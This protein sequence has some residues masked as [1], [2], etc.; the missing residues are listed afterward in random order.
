[1]IAV[2]GVT[3]KLSIALLGLLILGPL[4]TYIRNREWKKIGYYG[5]TAILVVFPFVMRNM[6]ISGYLLYPYA[7]FDFFD[8]DWKMPAYT[9]IFD[10]HEIMAWGRGLNDVEKYSYPFRVWFPEWFAGLKNGHKVVLVLNALLVFVSFVYA[11]I[12]VVRKELSHK[13][14]YLLLLFVSVACLAAWIFSAPLIRYGYVYLYL[15]PAI[16]L[17]YLSKSAGKRS[18]HLCLTAVPAAAAILGF[19]L[20]AVNLE[21][22]SLCLPNDYPEY[23]CYETDFQNGGQVYLPEEGDLTGYRYFPAIPYPA[24]LELIEVRGNSLKDGYRMK[25][26]YRDADVTTYGQIEG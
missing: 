10:N 26:E 5:A 14:D 19:F 23:A 7:A 1:M 8:V 9:V 2:F 3:V 17:G 12:S 18:F 6:M 25:Y 20:F 11:V 15:L 22:I 21:G 4:C 16:W 24:R 13:T